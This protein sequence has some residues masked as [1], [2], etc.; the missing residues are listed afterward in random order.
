MGQSRTNGSR[1][2]VLQFR[3]IVFA[4]RTIDGRVVHHGIERLTENFNGIRKFRIH[5]PASAL[6][7]LP[8]Q[9]GKTVIRSP[10]DDGYYLALRRI[11]PSDRQN[12]RCA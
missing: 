9:E 4:F 10:P 12:R 11:S 2:T 1:R 6:S 3:L 7:C 8:R 5:A